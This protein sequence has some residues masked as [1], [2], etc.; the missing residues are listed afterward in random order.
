[1]R[2]RT[3]DFLPATAPPGIASGWV[4]PRLGFA[5]AAWR[6]Q[7]VSRIYLLVLHLSRVA[8]LPGKTRCPTEAQ[9]VHAEGSEH[10]YIRTTV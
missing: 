1:M 9:Y 2:T 10:A 3:V 7:H 8:Q 5:C 4:S 6:I